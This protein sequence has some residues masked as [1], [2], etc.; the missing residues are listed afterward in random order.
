[1]NTV[2]CSVICVF[3]VSCLSTQT[4]VDARTQTKIID[5]SG[6]PS[7]KAA[8]VLPA[9]GWI[10]ASFIKSNAPVGQNMNGYT[11]TNTSTLLG[12]VT[13]VFGRNAAVTAQKGDLCQNYYC[14]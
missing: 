9:I 10:G 12:A 14:F 8:T 6:A 2:K 5:F 4:A 11:V 7:A 1:M 3:A 13:A